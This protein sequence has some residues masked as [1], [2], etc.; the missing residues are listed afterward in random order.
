MHALFQ[1]RHLYTPLNRQGEALDK[2]GVK[3][4][5]MPAW[6]SDP[7]SVVTLESVT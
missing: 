7:S 5:S 1:G 6:T 2:F 4:S 3:R